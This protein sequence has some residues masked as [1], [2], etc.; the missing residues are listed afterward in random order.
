MNLNWNFQ[1][2]GEGWG[3]N[4]K[5]LLGG[6]SVDIFWNMIMLFIHVLDL[7]GVFTNLPC[8]KMKP[9]FEVIGPK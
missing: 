9:L 3:S 2:G 6:R 1:G 5:T 4:P 7:K 8:F